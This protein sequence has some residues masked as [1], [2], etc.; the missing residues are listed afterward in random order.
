ML[1]DLLHLVSLELLEV[2]G[3]RVGMELHRWGLLGRL[4][5]GRLGELGRRVLMALKA[6]KE[7]KAWMELKAWKELK[8]LRVQMGHLAWKEPKGG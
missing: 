1:E 4:K 2:Q 3:Q 8:E 7:L 6:W 5:L